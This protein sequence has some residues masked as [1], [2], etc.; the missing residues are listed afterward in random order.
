MQ[1]TRSNKN[2]KIRNPKIFH[3]VNPEFGPCPSCGEKGV[4]KRSRPR[5]AWERIVKTITPF[6]YYRCKKCGWRGPIL[7]YVMTRE[8]AKN[9]FLYFIYALITALIV[10]FVITK[11]IMK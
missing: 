7:K 6:G 10:K 8:S 1:G 2:K 5:T 4:L 11:F 3:G 9:L